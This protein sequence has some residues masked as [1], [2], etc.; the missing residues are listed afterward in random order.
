[1]FD[2]GRFQVR[3][4]LGSMF[5]SEALGRLEFDDQSFLH[6]QVGH[7]VAQ[8]R[9]VF[10]IDTNGMLLVD[11][12]SGFSQAM[13]EGIFVDTFEVSMTMKLVYLKRC[14]PYAIT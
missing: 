9:T 7:V 12:E 6:A 8:H 5:L 13:R 11:L 4:Y 2:A 14:L 10:I 3:Q 1:M